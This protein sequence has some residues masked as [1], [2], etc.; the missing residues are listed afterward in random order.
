MLATDTTPASMASYDLP[1]PGHRTRCWA[2]DTK[3]NRSDWMQ[4][5]TQEDESGDDIP[6][7]PVLEDQEDDFITGLAVAPNVAVTQL[8]T[9]RELD[10]D[11]LLHAKILSLDSE[12]DLKHLT[13]CLSAESDVHEDDKPW[14]WDRLFSEVTCEL[15]T[16]C[17]RKEGIKE[18]D[19]NEK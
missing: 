5:Q 16:E 12:I 11:L 1:R 19:D 10:N 9:F 2:D 6:D 4:S 3:D 8:A 7:I 18:S 15:L 17:E 14:D 13:K